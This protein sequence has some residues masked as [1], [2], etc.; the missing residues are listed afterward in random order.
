MLTPAYPEAVAVVDPDGERRATIEDGLRAAKVETCGFANLERW[1]DSPAGGAGCVIADFESARRVDLAQRLA[2]RPFGVPLIYLADRATTEQV[3]AAIKAG[4]YD[5]LRWPEDTPTMTER[6][7]HARDVG[8]SHLRTRSCLQ[9]VLRR[10]RGLT[11]RQRQVMQLVARGLPNKRIAW[12]LDISERTVEV[13]RAA[14]MRKVGAESIA[15]LVAIDLAATWLEEWAHDTSKSR[16]RRVEN[17]IV[18][19][20]GLQSEIV[21][22]RQVA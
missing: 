16:S 12:Q 22:R 7:A 8:L 14:A 17:V 6:V 20:I 11:R 3:A 10:V 1:L 18:D 19:L 21:D 15:Q 5:F 2:S 4:A 13:H 9:A